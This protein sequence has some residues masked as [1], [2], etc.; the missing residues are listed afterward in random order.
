ML[1]FIK[2]SMA[3]RVVLETLRPE[4]SSL[5]YTPMFTSSMTLNNCNGCNKLLSTCY[6]LDI[7]AKIYYF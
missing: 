6:A 2:E 5:N 3:E 4:K 1:L 7:C